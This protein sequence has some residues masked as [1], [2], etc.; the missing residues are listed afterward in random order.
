[1]DETHIEEKG[2]VYE[3]TNFKVKFFLPYLYMDTIQKTI[4]LDDNF[5]E[6]ANL[7][8]IF[9]LLDGNIA[10]AVRQKD[11]MVLD[12][13]ANIGNHA[14][15]FADVIG[16]TKVTCF[17]A[18]PETYRILKKNITLN[19]LDDR[20]ATYCNGISD[21]D[22]KFPPPVYEYENT[23]GTSLVSESE[24]KCKINA[25]FF[26][27]EDMISCRSIDSYN[28]SNVSLIKIDVEG[29]EL[30]ALRGA[31]KTIGLFKPYII[32]ESYPNK[33]EGICKFL[34]NMNYSY[35]VINE[36]CYDYLFYPNE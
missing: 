5:Y 15:Y 7:N 24:D 14:I 8:K 25:D 30:K 6:A 22:E 19:K 26:E 20:I 1:M 17:E 11:G 18:V 12:I 34:K 33:F 27:E 28:F 13:G 32:I 3:L 21:T 9:G 2:M 31:E 36:N 29:M 4:F 23:G 35:N 10:K 16:A